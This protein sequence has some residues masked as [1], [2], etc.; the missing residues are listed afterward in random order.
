MITAGQENIALHYFTVKILSLLA[1]FTEKE[2]QFLAEIVQF[3]G[4]NIAEKA[5]YVN[6]VLPELVKRG[7]AK[8]EQGLFR[9]KT[10][11]TSLSQKDWFDDDI[12]TDTGI[13]KEIIAP[14][15]HFP[16]EKQEIKG[17]ETPLYMTDPEAGFWEK[18]AFPEE[19]PSYVEPSSLSFLA[20]AGVFLHAYIDMFTHEFLCGFEQKEL[21]ITL[22]QVLK[23]EASGKIDVTKDYLPDPIPRSVGFA[24]LGRCLDDCGVWVRYQI[25]YPL[26]K[27]PLTGQDGYGNG[28]YAVVVRDRNKIIAEAVYKAL[29]RYAEAMG[30]SRPQPYPAD[31]LQGQ[32][33]T[34]YGSNAREYEKV[35]ELW[36]K[37]FLSGGSISF[38]TS[39]HYSADEVCCRLLDGEADE[40][41]EPDKHAPLMQFLLAASD[42]R[43]GIYNETTAG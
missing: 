42:I 28:F 26:P 19:Q 16:P 36:E 8:E 15:H 30:K 35:K 9:I 11:K 4:D 39:F 10:L 23:A 41:Y 21:E 43:E 2:A 25:D 12:L 32:L 13:Q 7:I 5:V 34:V 40:R 17:E 6:A 20:R 27:K 22:R 1:G 14:F 37:T 24:P 33:E 29:C 38:Q 18:L 31:N 3:T